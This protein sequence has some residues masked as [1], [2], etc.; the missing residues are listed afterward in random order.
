[1]RDWTP[2]EVARAAGA[3]L[4]APPPAREGGPARAVV[5][6]RAT[7]RGDLFVG[8]PGAH[9]DG[10]AFA[11]HALAAGAWGVLVSAEHAD[12]ARSGS[13]G[14]LLA[15]SD[16]LRALQRLAREWRRALG[17][18]VIGITG[19]TGKTSTKDILAGMLA[20]HRRSYAS[21]ANLNTEIGVPLGILEAPPGTE[22]LVLEMAMRGPGQIAELCAIAEPDVGVI[23]SIGPVHLEQMGTLE[24]IAAE[25]SALTDALPAGGT[26]VIP[27]GER[28]L[29]PHRRPDVDTIT[30]GEAGDVRLV[31]FAAGRA[32]IDACGERFLVELPFAQPHNLTNTLAAIAAARAVGVHPAGRVEV[33]FSGLRGEELELRWRDG[34]LRVVNDC[35]NANPMSMRAALDH[36]AATAPGRRVAVLGDMLELG[37]GERAFHEDV[38]R[39]AGEAGV[40]VLVAVGPRA[41]AI[42]EAF[43]GEAYTAA[44]AA[45]AAELVPRLVRGGDTVLVKGSR[46]VAL[47]A[48]A[49][50]L[51]AAAVRG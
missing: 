40:E 26:A 43:D 22:V 17:A 49:E 25:K 44:D 29:E 2:E 14:V 38:G 42:G 11:P 18:D 21:R 1:V 24:A 27:A 32:V 10:G 37:P 16:P 13:P 19:S 36:L 6:S 33:A 50:A 8:L 45:A 41:A 4:V 20:A 15:A 12:A 9:A 28:L 31:S 5:D 48:V 3:R 39:H 46:G 35:Y 30:F 34:A 7:G 23:V 47:E 51:R